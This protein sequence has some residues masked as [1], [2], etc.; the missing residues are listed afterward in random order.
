MCVIEHYYKQ[1]AYDVFLEIY[2]AIGLTY[3]IEARQNLILRFDIYSLS[4]ETEKG[5]LETEN[6]FTDKNSATYNEL[7]YTVP[8]NNEILICWSFLAILPFMLFC[9]ITS[10]R[11]NIKLKLG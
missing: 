4:L 9:F 7:S 11:A 10:S 3:S 2:V 5:T 6:T 1:G 8:L